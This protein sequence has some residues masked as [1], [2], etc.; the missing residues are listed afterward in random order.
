M[1]YQEMQYVVSGDAILL[2][3]ALKFAKH[4]SFYF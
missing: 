4:A 2:K 3:Q 1:S